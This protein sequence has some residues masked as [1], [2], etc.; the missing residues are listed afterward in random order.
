M[1]RLVISI[2]LFCSLTY[3]SLSFSSCSEGS[4]KTDAYIS[5]L[6]SLLQRHDELERS[7]LMRI[8][9]L[10]Q[11]LAHAASPTD[12]YM[13]NSL[14]LDEF[15]TYNSDSA[16]K[17]VDYNLDIARQVGN[18]EWENRNNIIKSGLL[19]GSGLLATSE[20]IMLSINPS[21]LPKDILTDYYGQMIFLYSHLGNYTGGDVNDYYI[22]ERAYKDSIVQ[23]ID[24]RHPDYLWYKGWDILGTDKS[25]DK[26]IGALRDLLDKSELNTRKDAKDAYILAKLYEQ[27]GDHNNFK[28]YM[29]ISGIA[30]VKIV[31]AEI[32]SLEDLAKIMFAEGDVNRAYRYINYSLNKAISYPNRVKAYGITNTLDSINRAYQEQGEKQQRRTRFFL[33]LVCL[34]AAVLTGAIATIIVQNSRLRRRRRNLDAANKSLNKNVAKLSAAQQQLNDANSQLHQLNTDL[35]LKNDEL[36]EAN[37]VKEEYIGYIFT[38][39][40]NYIS[41]L[42]EL[43]RNIHIKAV[44]KKYKEIEAETADL[45]MKEELKDFYQSFDSIFLHI[46][47]NF[48]NDFNSLLQDDKKIIPR[49]GELLNT[50]LRI[51]ALVRL[52]ITDSVKIAEFLHCSV[53]TVYNNR[54]RVRNKAI[55]PKKDFAESVRTLGH[56]LDRSS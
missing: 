41:K 5:Q 30:D 28:K 2:I 43:K 36:N 19:A 17:Y 53:Q 45:D 24:S 1:Q 13:I 37:Y 46:Y 12:K 33:I 29:T 9:E 25:D 42:E 23:I 52:G 31:N 21:T 50:E 3:I 35:K 38:I 14:L 40:S 56:Y 20:E 11:K 7:K 4:S 49:E 18:K 55:I 6:D 54:F 32:S 39:C 48:V 16:M 8:G 10:R 34:L 26:L 44:T 15:S 22:K 27:K 47:P 51:Y